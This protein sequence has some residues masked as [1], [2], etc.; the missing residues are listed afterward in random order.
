M[1]TIEDTQKLITMMKEYFPTKEE[2]N[3]RFDAMEKRFDNLL[4]AVDKFMK[5][6][7]AYDQEMLVLNHNVSTIKNWMKPVS[8]KT[9]VEYPF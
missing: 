4:T 5:R 6:G 8:V 9:D 2:M 3:S 1:I 7:D